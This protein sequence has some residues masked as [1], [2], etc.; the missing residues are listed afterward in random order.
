VG[1]RHWLRHDAGT[2]RHPRIV[3]AVVGA[4]GPARGRRYV[5]ADRGGDAAG[6]PLGGQANRAVPGG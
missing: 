4:M 2:R 5:G 6:H 1:L 3:M